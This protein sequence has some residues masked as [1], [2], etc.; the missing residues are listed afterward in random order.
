MSYAGP[1]F[2]IPLEWQER[3]VKVCS[4]MPYNGLGY[5]YTAVVEIGENVHYI[6]CNGRWLSA[7]V[8]ELFGA[9]QLPV[10]G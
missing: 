4:L 9:E 6:A 3:G 10:I 2:K 1:T 8:C 7:T 5:S